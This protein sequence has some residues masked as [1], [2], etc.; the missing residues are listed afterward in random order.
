MSP[1]TPPQERGTAVQPG[2]GTA[3]EHEAAGINRITVGIIPKAWTA[4]HRL[5]ASTRLNRTDVVNR[6]IAVYDLVDS[7]T[8]DGYELVFRN[9]TTGRERVVEII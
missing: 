5:M 6:A 3:G 8:R 2:P 1:R 4:L 7:N 9:R